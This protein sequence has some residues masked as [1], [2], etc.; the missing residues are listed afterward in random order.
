MRGRS[1]ENDFPPAGNTPASSRH[2]ALEHES[3]GR[4]TSRP[5]SSNNPVP[6]AACH[7]QHRRQPSTPTLHPNE[8][9]P[10]PHR[11]HGH[12]LAS[13]SAH[14]RS[15]A[16]IFRALTPEPQKDFAHRPNPQRPSARDNLGTSFPTPTSH[17]GRPGEERTPLSWNHSLEARLGGTVAPLAARNNIAAERL[18][19]TSR[20][21]ARAHG[22][23]GSPLPVSC[24]DPP[25][26]VS[27]SEDIHLRESTP[28]I[29]PSRRL[30]N[31]YY[32]APRR[33][34]RQRLPTPRAVPPPQPS[35]SH[36]REIA[37]L[38]FRRL[39]VD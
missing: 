5:P 21:E 17:G 12:D 14:V 18:W 38:P 26:R 23:V 6:S 35:T 15:T 30:S 34:S 28:S 36:R 31:S 33:L 29:S 32:P 16:P 7:R 13:L 27:F 39:P 24:N 4:A 37:V 9:P 19:W 8:S 20:L 1:A 11:F 2:D 3:N 22:A 10:R 25:T